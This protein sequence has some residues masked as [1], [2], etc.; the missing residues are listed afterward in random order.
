[1]GGMDPAMMEKLMAQMGGAGGPPGGEEDSDDDDLP[2]L[3]P[4]S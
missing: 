4:S 2:D 3:E 1:M